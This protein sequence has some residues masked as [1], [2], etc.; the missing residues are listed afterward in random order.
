MRTKSKSNTNKRRNV[1]KIE[2]NFGWLFLFVKFRDPGDSSG[3]LVLE[4]KKK[5][6]KMKIKNINRKKII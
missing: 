5:K 1:K 2:T 3:W 4:G 6:K